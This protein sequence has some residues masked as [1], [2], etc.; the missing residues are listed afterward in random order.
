MFG[1]VCKIKRM[2]RSRVPSQLGSTCFAVREN[3]K[4]MQL[5]FPSLAS[6]ASARDEEWKGPIL[7]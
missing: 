3:E 1:D 5:E 2:S 7:G 4:L 6:V